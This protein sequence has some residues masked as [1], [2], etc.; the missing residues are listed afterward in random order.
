MT[1]EQVLNEFAALSGL[2]ANPSKSFVFCAGVHQSE[3]ATILHCLQMQEGF[4]LV[5]YL[6]APLTAKKLTV[7]DCA[8][9]LERVCSRIDYRLSKKFT[10]AGRLQLLSSVLYSLQAYWDSIFILP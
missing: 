2:K 1:I 3:R 8:V 5:R 7:D 10:F 6:G 4:L 9:L